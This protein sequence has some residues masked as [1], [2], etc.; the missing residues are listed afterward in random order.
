[1][2]IIQKNITSFQI[3]FRKL[4]DKLNQAQ[5]NYELASSG[6]TMVNREVAK[7]DSIQEPLI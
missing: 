1:M 3:E 5:S 6:L 4:G 7:L 2:R